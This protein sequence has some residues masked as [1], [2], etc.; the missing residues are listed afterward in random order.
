[1]ASSAGLVVRQALRVELVATALGTA[2]AA[3]SATGPVGAV[4]LPPP[5]PLMMMAAGIR[6][7]AIRM[8]AE[9]TARGEQ[10]S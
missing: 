4:S 10:S 2:G 3:V 1:M 6:A 9:I 5:P 8:A 7:P